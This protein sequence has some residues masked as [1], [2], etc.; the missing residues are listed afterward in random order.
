M[1]E[2]PQEVRKLPRSWLINVSATIVGKPFL[3]WVKQKICE[4]NEKQA[5][6]RNLLIK[7]DPQLAA[8]FNNS[9]HHSS[10]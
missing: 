1:P 4:R 3:D 2:T 7:M 9:T 5:R 8:A 6:E 10:K